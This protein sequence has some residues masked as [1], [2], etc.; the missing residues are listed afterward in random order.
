MLVGMLASSFELATSGNRS[1]DMLG[2]FGDARR[3]QDTAT[4]LQ[5]SD[6]DDWIAGGGE[7]SLL[8]SF[9]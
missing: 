5:N 6:G 9:G 3:L 4:V 1:V 8:E 7:T 2:R